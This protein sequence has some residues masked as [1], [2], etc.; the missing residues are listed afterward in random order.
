MLRLQEVFLRLVL[1]KSESKLY[2]S[3]SF[4]YFSLFLFYDRCTSWVEFLFG[5]MID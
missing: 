4:F 5:A 1:K 2:F 3:L